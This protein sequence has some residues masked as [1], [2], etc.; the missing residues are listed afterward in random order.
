MKVR[1]RITSLCIWC[2]ST[3]FLRF[4]L[5]LKVSKRLHRNQT[6]SSLVSQGFPFSLKL[7]TYQR[8]LFTSTLFSNLG[9]V[10]CK[11]PRKIFWCYRH[12]Q[13]T[14]GIFFISGIVT[15]TIYCESFRLRRS[16]YYKSTRTH[17]ERIHSSSFR[18]CI[19]HLIIGS[20][21]KMCAFSILILIY[22]FLRMFHTY[23]NR[24]SFWLH[25][26][27]SVIYHLESISCTMTNR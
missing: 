23:S 14:V 13:S 17:T 20:R 6:F 8:R 27:S 19:S 11:F 12:N 4:L 25:L 18:S 21:Q 5:F 7:Y 1:Q 10:F 24:K 3:K 9:S 16:I 15:H 2:N 26:K 22:H